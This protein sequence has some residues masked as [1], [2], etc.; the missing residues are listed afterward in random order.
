MIF[1]FVEHQ[2]VCEYAAI[3]KTID[4]KIELIK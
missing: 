3:N 2:I 1:S 4:Y